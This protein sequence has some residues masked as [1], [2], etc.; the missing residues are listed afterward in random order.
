MTERAD[1]ADVAATFCAT[2]ADE[3][4]RAGVR[5]VVVAPGS[6][7]TPLALAV[8]REA[9]LRVH[10]VLDE[11]SAAFLALGLGRAGELPA[12]VVTTSGTAAVELHPAVVEAHHDGVPLICAT[13]DRPPELQGVG[14]PQTV[15][16][17]GLYGSVVRWSAD[18]GPPDLA[19]AQSWR[20]LAA[21][22]VIEARGGQGRPPGPVHLNLAFREPLLGTP[23]VL[24]AGRDGGRPWHERLAGPGALDGDA[25]ARLAD[26][27]HGARGVIVA[28]V[29]AGDADAVHTLADALG[30]PVLADPRSGARL[31]RPHTV[32]YFDQ[33]LR[34]P[35][36]AERHRPTVV[37]RFG[38]PPASK[39]LGQ[40]LAASGAIEI[41]VDATDAWI[42][43]DRRAST[44]VCGDPAAVCRALADEVAR[45]A[46]SSASEL[47]AWRRADDAAGEAI[48]RTLAAIDGVT[49]PGIA[50]AALAAVPPGGAL[51]VSSSMPVRDI[52]WF[53]EP[54]RDVRVVANRGANGIDGVVS[55]AV[56]LALGSAEP[57]VLLIGDLAFLHDSN[58]LLGLAE[59]AVDLTIVVVDNRGGGIFSFLPQAGALVADEF[60]QLFGT[61]QP[62][63]LV[64]LA[65]AH[66]LP[67]AVASNEGE[68]AKAVAAGGPRVVVLETERAGNV[69]VHEQLTA[70]VVE[71]IGS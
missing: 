51:V 11:R 32:A 34:A 69:D 54:R 61:P 28:G 38:R 2:L 16:Q 55:T 44:F 13:A 41:V 67:A 36:F 25:C 27:L 42:D 66:G 59:R 65:G 33:L 17:V 47:D 23:T 60:E 6:R 12:V 63:D 68:I 46:P 18:P 58:G 21:R 50:R 39:V 8:A 29:G 31:V 64:A 10:V 1:P 70:A 56:G 49:E 30:W 52:E 45:R 3:W 14:A 71:A 53:G 24:P 43:P 22:S 20:S 35:V 62:V 4:V 40:W 5:D 57:V 26:I 9:G 7:S 19:A 15:E 48:E 37:L